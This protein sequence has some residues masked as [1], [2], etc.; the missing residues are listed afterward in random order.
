[1]S[2]SEQAGQQRV[3]KGHVHG[4]F[5]EVAQALSRILPRQGQGGASICVYHRGECVVDVW[6]GTRDR[7]GS[8][9][10][11]DTLALS[12]ST[13]KGVLATL[14]H[15]WVDRGHADYDDPVSRYWPR[16]AAEG[17]SGI[18]LRQVLC[19]E[20]GLHRLAPLIGHAREML[21]WDHMVGVIEKARPVSSK[22]GAPAYHGL[23]FGWLVGELIQRIGGEDL[24]TQMRRELAEPLGLDGLHLGLPSDLQP[25]RAEVI[26]RVTEKAE[27]NETPS[28]HRRRTLSR[29]LG[30]HRRPESRAE[31]EAA[32]LPPGFETLDW[33]S[34]E[35]SE[36]AIP[37][38]SGFFTARSLA[39]LYAR[40]C[41][42]GVSQTESLISSATRSQATKV[43]NDAP[44]RVIPVSMRW[45]L[46]YHSVAIAGGESPHAFGHFGLG[47]SGAWADP[48][49][50][51]AV[52]LVLNSGMGSP[53]GDSRIIRV[54]SAAVRA[55]DRRALAA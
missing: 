3:F 2:V 27:P 23:T 8:L 29:A 37:A 49:R 46:G 33:N 36:A 9:W 1:M 52:A 34:A 20:A 53:F 51:L 14:L 41:G 39:C 11:P 16:F 21:D 50:D 12:W 25:R 35:L 47:G 38:V 22:C 7:A 6:A 10:E 45:R 5:S 30:L 4:D 28:S 15:L 24:Q 31:A 54:N 44:G 43:Q 40:V 18:T 48:E 19:H 32:L 17:K 13:T 42:Q 55:A 26:E